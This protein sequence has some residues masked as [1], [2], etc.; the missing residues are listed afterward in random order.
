MPVYSQAKTWQ[1]VE[2]LKTVAK[3]RSPFTALPKR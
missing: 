2:F 3:N 1:G